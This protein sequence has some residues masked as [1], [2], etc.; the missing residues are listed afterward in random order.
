MDII[1][2]GF[3]RSPMILAG[4]CLAWAVFSAGCRRT[5]GEAVDAAPFRA[6][7][8]RYLD[9]HEMALA[10][11]AVKQGPSVEGDTATMTVSLTHAQLGGA[12]VTW[13]FSFQKNADGTWRAVS[14]HD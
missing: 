3:R 8:E 13:E 1:Y 10:I 6:A 14:H 2:S 12:A 9:Q 5:P 4:C 7:V 11:K